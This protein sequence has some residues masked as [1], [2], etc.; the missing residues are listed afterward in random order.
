MHGKHHSEASKNMW[1]AKR[2]VS[3]FPLMHTALIPRPNI[4][5]SNMSMI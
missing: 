4:T 5:K 3:F 2:A 1:I